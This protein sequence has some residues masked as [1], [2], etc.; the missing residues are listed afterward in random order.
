MQKTLVAATLAALFGVA[1]AANAADIYAP[2]G[3][4]KD[5]PVI[6]PTWTGFY[7]GGS[8]GGAW[9]DLK[10]YDPDGFFYSSAHPAYG[11]TDSN[12]GV[13]GGG[14]LGYNWQ[15][16][17]FVLGV[18]VDLDGIGLSNDN[19]HTWLTNSY[20]GYNNNNGAF[21][22]DVTGRLG[23]AYGPALFYVKGG[24]AYIDADDN[25]RYT[26]VSNPYDYT[27]NNN[28]GLSGWVIGGGVEYALSPSWSVK[29]EYLYYDFSR[30][31]EN[32][33]YTLTTGTVAKPVYTNY[34]A[35]IGHEL[36]I[37]T[38][39]VGINYHFGNVYTPL[40]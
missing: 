15:T 35:P 11:W 4:Y 5:V 13:V 3:G 22:F 25:L 28:N 39:K 19:N 27:W 2:G 6:A 14:Q 9:T 24:Y 32:I 30:E 17:A 21:L 33:S 34:Y 29:A 10:S 26:G 38:F 16:G 36:D 7:I 18:E 8:V 12:S 37:N 1:G 31:N 20:W 40:K 23:Y